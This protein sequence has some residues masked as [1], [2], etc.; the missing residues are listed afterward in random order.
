MYQEIEYDAFSHDIFLIS[1]VDLIS[2]C[3]IAHHPGTF[4]SLCSELSLHFSGEGTSSKRIDED[5]VH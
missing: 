5:D 4:V 3:A 2:I 1:I